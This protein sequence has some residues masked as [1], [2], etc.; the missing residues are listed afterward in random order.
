MGNKSLPILIMAIV[1]LS[2]CRSEYERIRSSG[3]PEAIYKKALEYYDNKDYVKAQG[4]FELVLPNYRG[5]A[6]AEELYYR[7]AYTYYY[8]RQYM[9]A[10]HYFNSFIQ[11]FGASPY[12][13]ELTYMSAYAA[14]MQSPTFRLDQSSTRKAID[15]LQQFINTYPT[16]SR[17]ATCNQLIDEL[18]QKLEKKAY[19]EGRLYF[20]LKNYQSS[21]K[22]FENLLRDFPE[23]ANVEQ[24]RYMILK[25]SFLLAENSIVEK[26]PERYAEAL[27]QAQEFLQKYA[28]GV[29][30]KEAAQIKET[31]IKK[32]KQSEHVGYQS[33]GT[34]S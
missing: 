25:A 32:I 9:M 20:D 31:S 33:K 18:R 15:E 1:L 4:L 23:T 13:E 5:K 14:Y 19:D 22:S 30:G 17:L 24:V 7:Y 11:T 16:S 28:G 2:S 10:S 34:R 26:Q 27:E 3:S 21:V 6:E 12:R 8:S 29:H